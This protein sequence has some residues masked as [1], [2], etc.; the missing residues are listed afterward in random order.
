MKVALILAALVVVLRVGVMIYR[1][2]LVEDCAADVE[3]E[4]DNDY[5]LSWREN[6]ADKRG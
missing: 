1:E 2:V 4:R 3:N 5:F 6:G